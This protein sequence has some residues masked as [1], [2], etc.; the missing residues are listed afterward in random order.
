MAQLLSELQDLP[1]NV[2]RAFIGIGF[3]MIAVV[4]I[5][6]H[7][8]FEARQTVGDVA[9]QQAHSTLLS[10]DVSIERMI[11]NIDHAILSVV[12]GLERPPIVTDDPDIRRAV[13]FGAAGAATPQGAIFVFDANGKMVLQSLNR[14]FPHISAVG[15]SFFDDQRE[16]PSRGLVIGAP[17]IG[18]AS[19]DL[20]LPLVR[21]YQKP[22]H[23]FGGIVLS[24]LRLG[25]VVKIFDALQLNPLDRITIFR[26]PGQIVIR[27][28]FNQ[29]D[30]GRNFRDAKLISELSQSKSDV[31]SIRSHSDG[32]ERMYVRH[33]LGDYPLIVMVAKSVDA[34][35]Q[36]WDL[37]ARLIVAAVALALALSIVT[38]A[39]L[40]HEMKI[41]LKAE[42]DAKASEAELETALEK[43]AAFFN[44]ANDSMI[45][46]SVSA[47]GEFVYEAV[48]PVWERIA[49]VP[50]ALAVGRHP[51]DVLPADTC[52]E[53]VAN[54]TR[55]VTETLT[56][57]YEYRLRNRSTACDWEGSVVPILSEKGVVT[58]IVA[59]CRDVTDRNIFEKGLRQTQRL[60][61]V[62]QLTAGIAHDFNNL[63]QGIVSATEILLDRPDLDTEAR[64]CAEVASQAAQQGATLV[65]RL[66]AFARK[67]QLHP[68]I[69]HPAQILSDLEKLLSR[70]LSKNIALTVITEADDAA[71]RADSAQLSNCLL[72][73]A[74]NARDAM[75]SGGSLRIRASCKSANAASWEGL[76]PQPYVCFEVEDTGVGMPADVIAR[77]FEPFFTTKGI[78]QGS[79]LGLSMVQ[80]FA[81]QSGGDARIRSAVNVGTT[82]AVWLPAV[83]AQERST[84]TEPKADMTMTQPKA[85][86]HIV[87]VDDEAIVARTLSITLQRFGFTTETLESSEKALE[88]LALGEN[89]D[90]LITDHSMPGLSGIELIAEMAKLR[91]AVPAILMS[92]Y[93]RISGFDEIAERTSVLH[94]PFDTNM[95]IQQVFSVIG[96]PTSETATAK[97][98]LP[99]A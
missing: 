66:L 32:Q 42:L 63:L 21:S 93:D 3:L 28:P 10:L 17:I 85:H 11:A 24:F 1:K 95:L 89:C 16:H 49:G 72:N 14:D 55:C 40:R 59:I 46:A 7:S 75:P 69:I 77:A 65:H 2:R 70:S 73:L 61:A 19:G 84:E 6:A 29:G 62:G 76:N 96:T 56:V 92:G 58:R 23:S 67:Q 99:V 90:L 54:W 9:E 13:L 18:R 87:V 71:V 30:V 33:Q 51:R 60:E 74:L 80:G 81:R 25:D 15:R 8:L 20:L 68:D 27:T 44:A 36:P 88:W 31:F 48:N 52:Q 5:L 83:A 34:I 26:P 22:D 37:K 4:C 94:K 82:V 41:R 50:A 86:G 57:R 47:D 45:I 79:G 53:I 98:A 91:P 43:L 38:G 12:D 35:Y 64:E 97:E 39:I 78:G